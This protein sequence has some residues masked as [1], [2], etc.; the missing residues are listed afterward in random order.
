MNPVLRGMCRYE[1][2]KETLLD[3]NDFAKMNEALR[4]EDENNRRIREAMKNGS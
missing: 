1:S 2:L 4:V 3:L